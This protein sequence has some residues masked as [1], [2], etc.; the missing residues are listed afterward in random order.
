MPTGSIYVVK[1][2]MDTSNKDTFD[3]GFDIAWY[4]ISESKY[5]YE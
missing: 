3:V 5:E 4:N 2:D 1:K